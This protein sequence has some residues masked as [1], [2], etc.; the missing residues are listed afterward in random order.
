[1]TA[2]TELKTLA[3]VNVLRSCQLFTGLPLTDLQ[4]VAAVSTIKALRKGEYLFREGTPAHGFYV[5]QTGAI[6]VH[7]VSATGKEQIIHVFRPGESFA[8][9]SLASEQGYPADARALEQSQV[10]LVQ[11]AGIIA[12]L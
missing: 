9:V 1:M 4:S 10:V 12:L 3:L 7:R 11:K 5:V 6:N 8:E 2:L